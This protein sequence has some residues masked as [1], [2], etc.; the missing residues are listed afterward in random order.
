MDKWIRL[1]FMILL[2]YN[3]L[4]DI[5]LT[6]KQSGHSEFKDSKSR[7]SRTIADKAVMPLVLIMFIA[8]ILFVE[9]N[10]LV[11]RIIVVIIITIPTI[12]QFIVGTIKAA[13]SI[14]FIVMDDKN[15]KE[16][17]IAEKMQFDIFV[18]GL[19]IV[20]QFLPMAKFITM[21][22]NNANSVN[23]SQIILSIYVLVI[24]PLRHLRKLFEFIARKIG[25]KSKRL[26]LYFWTT[27]DNL[28]IKARLTDI[29]I[30]YVKKSKIGL[31]IIL[32]IVGML[33]FIID[34]IYNLAFLLYSSIV[35]SCLGSVI[36]FARMIGKGIL[37]ALIS[38][39]EIPGYMVARN[40]FRLSG[41]IALFIMVI[42]NRTEVLYSTEDTF[43]TIT[44]FLASAIII[45]VI[46]D[47][48]Y[49]SSNSH[50]D[51]EV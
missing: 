7:N 40:A 42:I 46:F 6:L 27:W 10:R 5:I 22:E 16:I 13:D 41:I 43:L 20:Y 11:P 1:L 17:T 14:K 38:I 25:S 45:P 9:F 44:E 48:I 18:S 28:L 4:Y 29:I 34:A 19:L 26:S 50:S 3:M 30:D 8:L 21:V 2:I 24:D 36:T 35:C 32:S 47:W 37:R 31:K 33:T 39:T 49:S 12:L 51:S 15:N 23:F